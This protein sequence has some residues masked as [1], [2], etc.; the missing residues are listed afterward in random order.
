[1]KIFHIWVLLVL[2][3]VYSAP[4]LVAAE[5][6]EEITGESQPS[7]TGILDRVDI[8][9]GEIVI[10]DYL[11]FINSE[12]EYYAVDRSGINKNNF[13]TGMTAQY[14]V[15]DKQNLL[16]LWDVGKEDQIERH[17]DQ[18]SSPAEPREIDVSPAPQTGD[19]LKL[20]GG[21]WKN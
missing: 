11:Y 5:Y 21:V 17:A 9:N 1:M 14:L 6:A 19:G 4:P 8:D 2:V 3:A 10:D 12:T 16:A 18:E 13:I 15:D 20:E 7:G